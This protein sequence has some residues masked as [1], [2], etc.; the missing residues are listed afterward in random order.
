MYE[1]MAEGLCREIGGDLFFPDDANQWREA[2]AA[3][4]M[5]PVSNECLEYALKENVMG[6]WGGTT[7]KERQRMRRQMRKNAA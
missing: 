7:D 3:C 6:I 5:C 4:A 1:W 2:K